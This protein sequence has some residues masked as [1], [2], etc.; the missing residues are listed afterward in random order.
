M[1]LKS[2]FWKG[3]SKTV[4]FK[5]SHCLLLLGFVEGYEEENVSTSLS[6]SFSVSVLLFLSFLL[7]LSLS[8]SLSFSL[9]VCLPL[10][11][12]VYVCLS[13]CLSLSLSVCLSLSLS[14]WW[15]VCL[16]FSLRLCVNTH[17]T[18]NGYFLQTSVSVWQ[19]VQLSEQICPWDTLACCWDV[20]QPS[21]NQTNQCACSWYTACFFSPL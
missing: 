9:S 14:V 1:T 21:N 19:H 17:R 4:Y 2:T 20:K 16:C 6:L 7:S 5:I 8:L 18:K 12:C 13:L 15:S 3:R 11:L 10:L